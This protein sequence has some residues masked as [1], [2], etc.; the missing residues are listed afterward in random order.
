MKIENITDYKEFRKEAFKQAY[1]LVELRNCSTFTLMGYKYL[2]IRLILNFHDCN[3][4]YDF[5]FNGGEMERTSFYTK[6][7]TH[8][9]EM[10]GMKR[11][12]DFMN[13]DKPE[14]ASETK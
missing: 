13:F 9:E 14:L 2:D 5:T 4:V 8:E 6:D 11:F 3:E 7:T 12:S 10:E 1:D